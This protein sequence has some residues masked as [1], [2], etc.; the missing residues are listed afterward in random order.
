MP[1]YD[2][3]SEIF[4]ILFVK[5]LFDS[6]LWQ[7]CAVKGLNIVGPVPVLPVTLSALIFE[8]VVDPITVAKHTFQK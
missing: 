1:R 5:N 4:V 6:I 3:L 8:V 7:F 2:L